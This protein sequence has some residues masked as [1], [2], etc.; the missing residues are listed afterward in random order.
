MDSADSDVTLGYYINRNIRMHRPTP[1]DFGNS[2]GHV[3]MAKTL[4]PPNNSP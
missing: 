4:I 1:A 2:R 3:E